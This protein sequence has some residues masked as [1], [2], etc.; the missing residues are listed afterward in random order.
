[1]TVT[2]VKSGSKLQPGGHARYSIKIWLVPSSGNPGQPDGEATIAISTRPASVSPRVTACHLHGQQ[3]CHRISNTRY[4][5]TGMSPNQIAELMANLAV[6]RH[7]AG[8]RI[9]L[10]VLA[11]SPQASS[12][13]SASDRVV[14][15][16]PAPAPS[17]VPTP[18]GADVALP[19][20]PVGAP[21]TS[22]PDLPSALVNPGAGFPVI[23]PSPAPTQ[24][25]STL[26]STHRARLANASAT[27]PMD[28]RLIG[29][30]LAALALLA[31]AVTLA[32]ARLSLRRTQPRG[33]GKPSDT[34]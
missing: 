7:S 22:L 14:I 8:T 21:P 17:P 27:V 31:A 2:T 6:P 24:L 28:M 18:T 25:P 32:V 5:V 4:T 16:K 33:D 9:T 20:L 23:S 1:M 15:R 10:R 26:P 30:Q 11:T 34:T 19:P 12:P 3:T 29:G 13:T